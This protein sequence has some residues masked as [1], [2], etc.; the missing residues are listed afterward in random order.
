MSATNP[1]VQLGALGQSPWYDFITR[2]LLA[3]GELR[4]L[5]SGDGLLGMTSNPT[6]FEKAIAGSTDY[7]DDIRHLAAEG[8]GAEEIFEG[9]AIADVRA[10][11]DTFQPVYERTH[12]V[13]G[14]VSLEVSPALA[15]DG[16]ATEAAARRLWTAVARPNLMIKIPGTLEGLGA[17]ERCIADGINVN[18]TLL[19]AVARHEAVMEAYLKGLE[20]RLAAGQSIGGIA[21][22]AS[23]FVSRVDTKVDPLLATAGRADLRGTAAIANACLAYAAFERVFRGPRWDALAARGARVQRPLWASTSTKDPA[24]PDVYY[25][26]ALVA[27]QTVNTL[28]PETFAAYRDHGNP[29]VRLGPDAAAAAESRLREL[30]GAGI[31]LDAATRELEAEGVQKFAASFQSLLGG[32]DAKAGALAG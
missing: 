19:F 23:F 2:E 16:E 29:A 12:G 15:H 7:D 13:D 5:I 18:V 17:I 11:C 27:P 21:S 25:V 24:L 6:I 28:P 8:H 26:E 31:D 10:A 9:L 30:A 1:L 3:T 20:R 4:A 22:V 32:I 14:L